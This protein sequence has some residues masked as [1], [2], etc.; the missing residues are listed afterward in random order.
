MRHFSFIKFARFTHP[1][2]KSYTISKVIPLNN[3]VSYDVDYRKNEVKFIFN[4]ITIN[5][6]SSDIQKLI[7]KFEKDIETNKKFIIIDD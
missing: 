3:L 1:S 7:N 6:E 2:G 5:T 4:N